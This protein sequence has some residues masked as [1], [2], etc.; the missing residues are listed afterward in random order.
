MVISGHARSAHVCSNGST[1][2]LM[3]Q[4]NVPQCIL[5]NQKS[6]QFQWLVCSAEQPKSRMANNMAKAFAGSGGPRVPREETFSHYNVQAPCA[7]YIFNA[8]PL[9]HKHIASLLRVSSSVIPRPKPFLSILKG[10]A[11]T[12]NL[13]ILPFERRDDSCTFLLQPHD[14]FLHTLTCS[15]LPFKC[16]RKRQ[17]RLSAV[18][19]R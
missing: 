5:S 13:D 10:N 16:L 3:L 11:E 14:F 7:P 8:F 19:P 4:V 18:S 17:L 9:S 6:V 15:I 2:G 12:S 1:V